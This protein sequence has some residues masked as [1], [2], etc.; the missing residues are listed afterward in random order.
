MSFSVAKAGTDLFPVTRHSVVLAARSQEPAERARALEAVIAVYW[1]PVYK[2]VRRKWGVSVED[3]SDFT[4]EFFTRLIEKEFLESYDPDKGRLR[5]FLRACVDRFFM[6]QSRDAQRIKRGAGAGRLE[7]ESLVLARLQ[8]PGIVP[9]HDAGRLAD[10]RVFYCMKYVE[11]ETLDQHVI[12]MTVPQRLQ[13]LLRIAEPLAFAHAQGV[14]H[15]DLKPGN[16]MIGAFGEVLI[17]DWGLARVLGELGELNDQRGNQGELAGPQADAQTAHGSILGTPGY[18][19][20]EQ[21]RGD[22]DLDERTDV[23]SLGALLRFMLY[24]QPG[25]AAAPRPLRAICDKAMAQDRTA[26]YSSVPEMSADIRRFLE[27][28][29]IR[30]YREGVAER[31]LR[32]YRRHKVA[33]VLVLAYVVMRAAFIFFSHRA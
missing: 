14:L 21:A 16:I 17:M 4:Q 11:G 23:F 24:G 28:E 5:T 20:P 30:A 9:V 12:G 33:V 10:G 3:A 22:S 32:L 13:L 27:G 8:H 19:S 15:R 26:R 25:E 1:K 31:A 18:M 7:R 2:H 29:P 6:N